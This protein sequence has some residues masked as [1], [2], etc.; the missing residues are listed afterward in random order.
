[1]TVFICRLRKQ[2]STKLIQWENRY[3]LS[4]ADL[5]T[6]HAAAIDALTAMEAAFHQAT[7]NIIKVVT[8]DLSNDTFI[9]ADTAIACTYG[10]SGDELPGILTVNASFN[11]S[12]FGRPD[13]KFYHTYYGETAQT[14]GEWTPTI[15]D[16]VHDALVAGID[17]VADDDARLCDIDGN[18]WTTPAVKNVVGYHQFSKRSRRAVAAGP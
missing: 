13:R 12:A 10:A 11:V 18:F 5:A 17:A 4:A 1:M 8:S 14:G 9:A 7:I 6:A 3:Y 15:T 2:H 16:A